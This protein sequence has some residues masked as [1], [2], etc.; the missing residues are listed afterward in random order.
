MS[1]ELPRLDSDPQRPRRHSAALVTTGDAPPTFALSSAYLSFQDWRAWMEAGYLDMGVPTCFY[2][3]TLSPLWYRHWVDAAIGW[4]YGRHMSIGVALSLNSFADAKA[5]IEYARSAGADGIATYSYSVTNRT[6]TPPWPDWYGYAGA[7]VFPTPAVP[8]GMPWRDPATTT[9]GTLCGQVTEAGTGEPIDDATVRVGALP[10]VQTDGNGYY[11][12]TRI[13]TSGSGASYDVTAT[14]A[15]WP[16]VTHEAVE[17][18]PGAVAIDNLE[19][20]SPYASSDF[21][22]DDDVDLADFSLLA[23]CFNGPNRAPASWSCS[24]P[25][26][27]NDGDVDLADFGVFAS[28]FNGP[29]RLPVCVP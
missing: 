14:K 18:V 2:D 3:E 12:V 4:R 15:G 26:L 23:A 7:N 13:P 21:N 20:E 22:Q 10:P 27:D 19:L 25:D 29:N 28:C 16:S 5:Q 1:A 9:E 8:P 17:L 6:G 24:R 11:A